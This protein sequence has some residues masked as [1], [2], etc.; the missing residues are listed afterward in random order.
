MISFLDLHKIN[1]RF[2]D[3]FTLQFTKFLDSGNYILG[4]SVTTFESNFANYCGTKYCIGTGNGLDA[5]TL[6][7]K[8]YIELGRINIGD[9][10][11]V[12]ANTYIASILSIINAGL[13]PILVEPDNRSFNISPSEIEKNI[14]PN[15][16][17]ILMVHL[18]GQLAN[19]DAIQEIAEKFGLL[20]IEDA[21]QAHGA[22]DLAGKKAGNLSKAGA[23][24]FYPTKNLG[25][26]GDAGAV[27]TNDDA[28]ANSIR[29]LRNYGSSKKYV[30]DIVGYNSRLDE[31]QAAFLNIKLQYLDED[32][33]KRRLIASRYL[34]EINNDKISLPFYSGGK[35]HV[36]YTLVLQVADRTHFM[37]YLYANQVG[38]LIHYPIA[39][40]KQKALYVYND[41]VLPITE[42]IHNTIISIPISPVMLDEEVNKV[43]NVINLY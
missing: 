19:V 2:K 3:E 36:F 25:A 4:D 28:L 10:V 43:I 41:L 35:D 13:K 40:H 7:F 16:K 39:P 24:S 8:G 6:I 31:L 21:A 9:E 11:I 12:P 42:E 32:N 23:F 20:M 15:S 30:N 37:E 38:C 17:A 1:A 26:L 22:E 33:N 29:L 18:Y 27:T 34:T 14:T 5:L